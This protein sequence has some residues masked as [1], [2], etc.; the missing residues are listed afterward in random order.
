ML[1]SKHA[2]E[3]H[4]FFSSIVWF[5]ILL[6]LIALLFLGKHIH[7]VGLNIEHS[8]TLPNNDTISTQITGS[9]DDL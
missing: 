6:F 4:R 2:L 7:T 3:R 1:Q 5:F 8:M 9:D